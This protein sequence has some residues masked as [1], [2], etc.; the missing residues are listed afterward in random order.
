MW[1]RLS[2]KYGYY[3]NEKY[4][5]FELGFVNSG[6][7]FSLPLRKYVFI[8]FDWIKLYAGYSEYLNMKDE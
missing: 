2:D 1:L 8:L 7:F 6:V 4:F 5:Y 3:T